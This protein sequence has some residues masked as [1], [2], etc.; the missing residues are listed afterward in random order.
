MMKWFVLVT[1]AL[2][3]SAM[4]AEAIQPEPQDIGPSMEEQRYLE[5]VDADWDEAFFDACTENW[6]DNWLLDGQEARITH[7]DR[8]MD[9]FA[10]DQ[11]GD[12]A[13]H[14]VLWTL[15]SFA[16]DIK[17]EYEY[18]RLDEANRFVTI[19]YIQATGSGD[20]PYQKDIMRWVD[21]RAVPSMRTY[22]N[23]MNTYHISYAAYG[24]ENDDPAE[25][26][27][28]ARR[29]MP[30]TPR[31]L[32]GTD[33]QPDDYARTGLFATGVPYKITVIKSG[34]KLYM[35]IAGKDN[36]LLCHWDTE[37]FP[38]I[39]EGRIGL[40]HMYTRAARYRNFRVSVK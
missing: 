25:D 8:G 39:A 33:L 35:H 4:G 29:Y 18:T 30:E 40:R 24:V 1:I 12:D 14:A 2:V 20:G 13:S 19:L 38:A 31:G 21:R 37:S 22:F 7:S 15:K 5:L 32:E 10:G 9:F 27:I 17:I 23:H 16:G 34:D 3:I 26:Y 6:K 28:R 11:A 36:T